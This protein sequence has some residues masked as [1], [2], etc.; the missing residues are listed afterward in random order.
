MTT[1][2]SIA[3]RGRY[4]TTLPLAIMAVL[5]QTM[6]V[7][8]LLVLD[9]NDEPEDLRDRQHYLYM[10]QMLDAKGIPWE[11]RFAQKKGQHYSHQQANTAGYTWVWRIDDDCVPEPQTLERLF[12]YA[13]GLDDVG[14]VG[15]SILTPP[16]MP[17][18]YTANVTGLIENIDKEPNIQWNYIRDVKE[19]DHLHCSFLYRAGVADF[20]LELSRVAHREETL[21]TYALKQKGYKI[22]VVPNADTWHLKNKHGGIRMEAQAMFEHDEH[23]FRNIMNLG[24]QTIVVLDCG[25]GDHIVFKHVLPL[26]KNPLVFSCYPDIIPGRSIQDAKN[27]YGDIEPYNIYRKMDLWKWTGSLEDAFRKLYS[28]EV[29]K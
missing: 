4:D 25:R 11:I 16:L 3:T 29:P 19:V 7:D 1:L 26:I 22:L 15:G 24:D 21:F 12:Y 23:I 13:T 28:V 6:K 9:D 2:C 18:S 8:K 10:M 14:A 5:N 20:N 17:A 27:L